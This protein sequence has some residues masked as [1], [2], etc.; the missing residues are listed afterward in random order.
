MTS[1]VIKETEF[2][3]QSYDVVFKH[4][5]KI[6]IVPSGVKLLVKCEY[7]LRSENSTLGDVAFKCILQ[8]GS[9]SY[10]FSFKYQ[11]IS[12]RVFGQDYHI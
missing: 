10:I 6:K 8:F 11:R 9:K 12:I 2:I 3:G 1:N 4:I 7:L 5:I